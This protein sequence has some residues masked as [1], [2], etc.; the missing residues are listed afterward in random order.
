MANELSEPRND[1]SPTEEVFDEPADGSLLSRLREH[2][3]EIA[4][5]KTID[6]DIPGFKG[7]LFCRYR[8]L[9]GD[10]VRKIQQRAREQFRNNRGE[11]LFATVCDN[12]ITACDEFFVRD[13]GREIPA[14][15]HPEV[16]QDAPIK[17]DASLVQI[18][19]LDVPPEGTR[20]Q[21]V[22][23]LFGGNDLAVQAHAGVLT[24]WMMK[25]GLEVDL[26]LGEI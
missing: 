10:E 2:R 12:L 24:R 7:E 26:E 20:R 5:N 22:M 4:E 25:L 21:V 9:D 15:E 11:Q 19:G 1:V 13:E 16:R 6:I 14:R 3:K 17:Y 18:L 8:L 23:A